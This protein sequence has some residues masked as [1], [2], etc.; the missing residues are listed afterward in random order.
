[1]EVHAVGN[2]VNPN[3]YFIA[4]ASDLAMETRPLIAGL[5]CINVML[6][7][8]K[9]V[10]LFAGPGG[11]GEGFA[12]YRGGKSGTAIFN[13]RLSIEKDAEAAKTLRL[14]SFF[15]QFA[16]DQIPEEYYSLL[17]DVKRPLRTFSVFPSGVRA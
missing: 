12:A 1:M 11:L 14:R 16:D 15:R 4:I 9:G 6:P 3:F 17:K 5:R 7:A 13:I 8:F 10:D 2:D